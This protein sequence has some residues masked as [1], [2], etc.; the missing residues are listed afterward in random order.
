MGTHPIFESD[1][2]CLTVIQRVTMGFFGSSSSSSSSDDEDHDYDKLKDKFE[3]EKKKKTAL[4]EA[5][6]GA[7][8]DIQAKS[9]E[10]DE[11]TGRLD[12][13]QSH[14]EDLESQFAEAHSQLEG[15]LNATAEAEE[16]LSQSQANHANEIDYL[17]SE[18]GQVKD[19]YDNAKN[20]HQI[21][22]MLFHSSSK[23]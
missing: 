13:E 18:L 21:R 16:A 20:E 8:E 19:E 15:A 14:R 2:D 7:H 11:L 5:L 4:R 9:A 23:K 17:Q 10:V 12:A 1:F 3:A 22:L 6:Q